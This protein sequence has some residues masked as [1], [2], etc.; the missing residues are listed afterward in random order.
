MKK[1]AILLGAA[2]VPFAAMAAP[3][4]PEGPSY[5][6]VQGDYI[7][8]GNLKAIGPDYEGYGL[9]ASVDLAPNL[10][11]KGR[12]E[13]LDA[14]NSRVDVNRGSLGL[15]LHDF[16]SYGGADGTGVGYYGQ[17]SY[18]RLEL[19]NVVGNANTTATGVGV[20]VGLR[21]MVDPAVE[22]NPNIGYV[23]YGR[24]SGDGVSFGK[25]DGM[26]YSMRALGHITDNVAL[27]AEYAKTDYDISP[28]DIDFDN[29]VRVGARYSF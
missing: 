12:I 2:C 26:R 9:E 29:E 28:A 24:N 7:P 8:D 19:Q 21:W 5:N 20:D 6:Y 25:A 10:Y 27:S 22:I 11:T 1:T 13:R 15:G 18:E 16:Y 17:V 23:K 3:T 4:T 14:D